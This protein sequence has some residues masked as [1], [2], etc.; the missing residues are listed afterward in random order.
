MGQAFTGA[1]RPG[2]GR[3][4][5]ADG[6]LEAAFVLARLTARRH[7]LFAMPKL[8]FAFKIYDDVTA[9][10]CSFVMRRR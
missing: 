5:V 1:H 9:A 4:G 3:Q 6:Q 8:S 2:G 7:H 10:V